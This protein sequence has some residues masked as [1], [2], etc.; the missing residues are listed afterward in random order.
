MLARGLHP[1]VEGFTGDPELPGD[2]RGRLV[3]P[4]HQDHG[5]LLELLTVSGTW[6]G[7]HL[8]WLDGRGSPIRGVRNLD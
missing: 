4:G 6:H 5:L 2:L 7:V 1:L 3:L 8:E